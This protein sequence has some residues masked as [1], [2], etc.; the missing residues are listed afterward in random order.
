MKKQ[1][2]GRK[3]KKSY[4]EGW[5]FKQQCKDDILRDAD[6]SQR[7]SD[8]ARCSNGYTLAVIPAFHVDEH[9]RKCGTLQVITGEDSWMFHFPEG[10]FEAC[11]GR[12]AIR[13]GKNLFTEKGIRLNLHGHGIDLE[14]TIRFDHFLPPEKE[15]MGPF[16]MIPCM[17]CSHQVLSLH[18]RLQGSVRLNGQKVTFNGGTG[19]LEK[20]RGRSFPKQYLWT[21]C[22][23]ED[24]GPGCIM[25]A[26]AD[27]P[28]LF[29]SFQ[30]CICTI[31]YQG[32][33]HR[34]ATYT[35]AK[36]ITATKNILIIRQREWELRM[37]LIKENPKPLQAPI[38][39]AMAF[40]IKESA[41]CSVQ[42]ELW[43]GNQRIFRLL[44]KNAGWEYVR[45][46][47]KALE[48][49]SI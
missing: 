42:Y 33:Q 18:H 30:G 2:Y 36:V 7:N 49:K 29:G 41:A 31:L 48:N 16:S 21:Q 6:P 22:N 17:Q 46:Q 28:F 11:T 24:Q 9:G 8:I 5:Y 40:G 12:L 20:D 4:F 26:V 35:G 1:F 27:V 14:G 10:T 34:F 38:N 3:K 47:G 25:A 45:N 19:Y 15:V 23:F 44:S 37:R 43:K 32:K 39:G 13:L